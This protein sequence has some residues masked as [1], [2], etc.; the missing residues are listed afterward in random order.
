M[1]GWFATPLPR[2]LHA[3][4]QFVDQRSRALVL[5]L[6]RKAAAP[7]HAPQRAALEDEIR[8]NLVHRGRGPAT[9]GA[10]ARPGAGRYPFGLIVD[11]VAGRQATVSRSIAQRGPAWLDPGASGA[12]G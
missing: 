6:Y 10:H 2:S 7:W 3:H 5:D 9:A 8:L 1:A 4:L 12:P 11:L